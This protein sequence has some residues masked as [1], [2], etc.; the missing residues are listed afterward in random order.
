VDC[1]IC[2]HEK[3]ASINAALANDDANVSAIARRFDVSKTTLLRHRSKHLPTGPSP[4]VTPG[5]ATP[6]I[7]P[8]LDRAPTAT[9][10]KGPG[11]PCTVCHSPDRE[12]IEAHLL[13]GKPQATIP[14]IVPGSPAH[15]AIRRHVMHCIPER[16]RRAR[17]EVDGMAALKMADDLGVLR[18]AAMGLMRDAQD[19]VTAARKSLDGPVGGGGDDDAP[20][21]P[22]PGKAMADALRAAAAVVGQAKSVVELVG[23]FTGELR[24]VVEVDIRK[25]KEWPDFLTRI[26]EAVAGCDACSAAVEAA[27]AVGEGG[28]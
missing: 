20:P 17:A 11:R 28:S 18:S 6:G 21:P 27:F 26:G 2:A 23:K 3:A 22:D 12:T 1:T 5:P 8:A 19:L 16:M 7:I 13:A 25:A 15:D 24:T 9:G 4:A 10:R 14:D